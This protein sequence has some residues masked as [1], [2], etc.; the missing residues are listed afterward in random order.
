[1][2]TTKGSGEVVKSLGIEGGTAAVFVEEEKA[3]GQ[4]PAYFDGM[5]GVFRPGG[6]RRVAAKGEEEGVIL[7]AMKHIIQ[8]I[9]SLVFGE[10]L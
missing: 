9:L 2:G 5:W 7:P 6:G 10:V 1:M 8:W 3:L 4:N